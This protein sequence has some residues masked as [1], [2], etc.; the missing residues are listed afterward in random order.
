MSFLPGD[1]VV[2]IAKVYITGDNSSLPV[3]GAE[4]QGLVEAH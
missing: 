2:T 1:K 4:G 3:R